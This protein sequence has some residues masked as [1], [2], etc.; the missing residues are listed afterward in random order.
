MRVAPASLPPSGSVRP[1]APRA[2]PATRSGSQRSFCSSVPNVKIG[3]APRPTPA[4]SVMPM[5]W[6][7]R[8]ISSM[9]RH[10][11]VKSAPDAAVLLG[12]D[13]AEQAELAHGQHRLER[14]GVVAV[15]GLGMG[16]DLGLGEVSHDLAEGLLLVAEVDVHRSSSSAPTLCSPPWRVPAAVTASRGRSP[17]RAAGRGAHRR[18]RR[19]SRLIEAVL[20]AGVRHLEAGV[21]RVA[22]GGAGDGRRGRGGGGRRPA[23][24]VWC[25]P[26]SVPNRRGAELALDG[27]RRRADR[28]DLGFGGLQRQERA[29]DDR[30]VDRRR[31]ARSPR[32]RRRRACPSTP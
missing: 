25:A 13:Q 11:V 22:E 21:V 5:L 4:D 1:K 23:A 28:H 18:S 2:R 14:E 6:S 3:L 20:A 17:R 9:A 31:P 15:P 16:R 19:G 29:H 12:E 8:P 7:T 32:W 24:R 27:R 10:S 26:R 30:G